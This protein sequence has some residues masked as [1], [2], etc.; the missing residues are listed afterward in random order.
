[1]QVSVDAEW[2]LDIVLVPKAS[3]TGFTDPN[4][5]P[6]S[7]LLDALA[8]PTFLP[9]SPVRQNGFSAS[10]QQH[11]RKPAELQLQLQLQAGSPITPP[12]IAHS[13]RSCFHLY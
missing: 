1:M 4:P 12:T 5:L 11:D 9:R 8:L 7:M 3:F 2:E 13:F 10:L 6:Y